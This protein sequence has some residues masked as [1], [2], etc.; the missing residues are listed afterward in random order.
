MN[1][2]QAARLAR[3]EAKFAESIGPYMETQRHVETLKSGDV[4]V[5]LY[6]N[7]K[8]FPRIAEEQRLWGFIGP[9]GGL[10]LMKE[11][12]VSKWVTR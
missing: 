8:N 1:A 9:R 11:T 7:W 10:R 2:K 12:N 3:M 6:G 4:M 5:M